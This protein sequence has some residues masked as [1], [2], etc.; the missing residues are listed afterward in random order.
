M[1]HLHPQVRGDY[2]RRDFDPATLDLDAAVQLCCLELRRFF[3]DMPQ[4]ALDKK[5]NIEYLEREVGLR[6]VQC[7]PDEMTP[8][9]VRSW[10]NVKQLIISVPTPGCRRVSQVQV[11]P[12]DDPVRVQ[13][14]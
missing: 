1:G 9:G 14:R 11:S 4:V 6:Q 8:S 5:A 7:L 13:E 12:E 10:A 2:L 3:R